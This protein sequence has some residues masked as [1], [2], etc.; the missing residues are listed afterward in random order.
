MD[1]DSALD[2]KIDNIITGNT[3]SHLQD[4]RRVD[5]SKKIANREDRQF[6]ESIVDAIFD[7]EGKNDHL[8][9]DVSARLRT[10]ILVWAE[11]MVGNIG[12][13]YFAKIMN[14]PH[15]VSGFKGI[16]Q[17]YISPHKPG[18]P[19]RLRVEIN[20]CVGNEQAG[21]VVRLLEDHHDTRVDDRRHRS[22]Q[23]YH[24]PPKIVQV[25]GRERSSR[26]LSRSPSPRRHYSSSSDESS[27][28]EEGFFAKVIA[29][30]T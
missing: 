11:G 23:R 2:L 4:Y 18:N 27:E 21:D 28:S 8:K 1:A 22:R 25:R 5:L 14:I 19:E 29:L 7:L 15:P 20:S 26:R 9:V 16:R 17:V 13:T 3:Y 6:T 12:L 24:S 30:V 10:T